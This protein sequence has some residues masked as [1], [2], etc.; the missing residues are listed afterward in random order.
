MVEMG[1]VAPRRLEDQVVIVTGGTG[2]LGR[3]FVSALLREGSRVAFAYHRNVDQA[4]AMAT[5]LKANGH[6][7]SYQVDVRDAASVRGMTKDVLDVWGRIDG[8]INNAAV[9]RDNLLL[10]LDEAAWRDVIDVNLSGTYTVSRPVISHMIRSHQGVILNVGSVSGL[11]GVRG[12]TNYCA[13]KAGLVGFTRALAAEVAPH[14]IRVNV[15]VPG[16][17]EGGMTEGLSKRRL[18][19]IKTSIPFRRFGRP[20]EIVNVAMFLLSSAASYITGQVVCVD[21]GLSSV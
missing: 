9:V 5:A 10:S 21:G 8:L 11:R 16:A 12:Q 19:E 4:A 14:G 20:E 3:A 13:A 15:L 18:D 2:L 7:R 1:E 6:L 17:I